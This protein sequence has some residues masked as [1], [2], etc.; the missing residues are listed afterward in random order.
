MPLVYCPLRNFLYS[1]IGSFTDLCRLF[2][3]DKTTADVMLKEI[4]TARARAPYARPKS[5]SWKSSFRRWPQTRPDQ[6]I[7]SISDSED[8][9]EDVIQVEAKR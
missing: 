9:V 8:E 1:I 7:I 3:A 4:G 2:E 5:V 6:M